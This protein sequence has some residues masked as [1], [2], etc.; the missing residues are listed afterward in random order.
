MAKIIYIIVINI[1]SFILMGW[2]KYCAK[3]NYWRI[4]ESNLLGIA[5]LGGG[6]GE[7]IGMVAFRHKTKKAQFKIGLPII[8]IINIFIYISILT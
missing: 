8:V 1:I 6:I 3:K 7:I 4:S 5:I 2:D